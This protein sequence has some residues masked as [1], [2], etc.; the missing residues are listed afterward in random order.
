MAWTTPP[1]AP[2]RAAPCPLR[3][4][5]RR[6]LGA[7]TLAGGALLLGGCQPTARPAPRPPAPSPAAPDASAAT[8]PEGWESTWNA[9]LAAA[10]EEGKVVVKGPPS[11]EV[12]TDLPRAF[13]ARYG[14]EVE[15]LGSPTG[16]FATQLQHEREAGIYSTDV[17]LAGADS[18]YT[19]F[20]AD[21]MLAPL[22][23]VLILPEATDP[24]AWPNGKLWFMDPDQQYVLRLNNSVTI[25]GQ[26][27]T[28]YVK[29]EDVT[30][31]SDLLKPEY[32]GK[33]ACFDPAVSGSGV[34]TAAYLYVTLGED[35]VRRLY[36]DQQ[37]ALSRDDR[38]LA[39]WVARGTYPIAIG[40]EFATESERAALQSGGVSIVNLPRPA[41]AP[42]SV[43][44]S[45]GL[46][47]LLTNAPHPYAAQVFVNWI[48][49]REGMT[50]W[51][52]A[53]N[54][55]PVRLDID[56][57][58]WPADHV[59]DPNVKNYHDSY[60][61]DFVLNERQAVMAQLRQMIK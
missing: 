34:G 14:I 61:W 26:I 21:H 12:R 37:P 27:N 36:V 3:L 15:Y 51:S 55:V 1:P 4:S 30:R 57:S 20:Y 54:A 32:K 33:I 49:A 5:R 46:L 59:P 9:W 10:R 56:K 19:V 18:M 39:D 31:W 23:P 42:G 41:D 50:V 28:A 24:A 38:Q 43:S 13:Q 29:P 60:G 58:A 53:L 52:K 45:F 48:A 2:G 17:V 6:F 35:Y 25:M 44:P 7:A 8:S 47:G 40:A 22:P 16:P 11:P